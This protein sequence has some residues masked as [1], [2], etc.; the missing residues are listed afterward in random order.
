MPFTSIYHIHQMPSNASTIWEVC[1][2]TAVRSRHP[3]R[4]LRVPGPQRRP[5]I[6]FVCHVRTWQQKATKSHKKPQKTMGIP[7]KIGP[8][9]RLEP[10]PQLDHLWPI[11]SGPCMEQRKSV[12]RWHVWK[13]WK[14]RRYLKCR[15]TCDERLSNMIMYY[16]GF[17]RC[18]FFGGLILA[19][20]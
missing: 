16:T 18:S 2:V 12:A 3:G 15:K 4:L 9:A 13:G 5:S 14:Q 8:T 17:F 1:L 6:F 20:K 7:M 19:D 10:N 11:P